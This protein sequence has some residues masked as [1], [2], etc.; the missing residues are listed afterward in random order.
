MP[1]AQNA[2]AVS[3][4]M[5][6]PPADLGSYARTMHQHTKRQMESISQSS[7]PRG[8]QHGSQSAPT[9]LPDGLSGR[10]RNSSQYS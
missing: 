1:T 3:M 6:P 4:P 10:S 5:P 7:T 2:Y 8:S 9:G